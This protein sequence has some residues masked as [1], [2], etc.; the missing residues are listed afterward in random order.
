[1][2][3]KCF[4]KRWPRGKSR[5]WQAPANLRQLEI[6]C[7]CLQKHKD[8]I[9]KDRDPLNSELRGSGVHDFSE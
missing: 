8:G 5:A 3:L 7:F 4:R 2:C 9:H 1:M 6:C